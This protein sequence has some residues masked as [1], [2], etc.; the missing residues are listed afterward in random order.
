MKSR[1]DALEQRVVAWCEAR[2]DIRAALVVGSRARDD[3][4][5]DDWA[6][7]DVGIVC[8][9]P[10]R[11]LKD[12]GWLARIG[13]PLVASMD[14]SGVTVHVLFEDGADGG[15]AFIPLGTVKTALRLLPIAMRFPG[16]ARALPGG[17]AILRSVEEA[18]EYYRRGSRIIIDKDGL[19]ARMMALFPATSVAAEPPSAEEFAGSVRQ[20]WFAAVWMAKHLRRG[21]LWRTLGESGEGQ[22]RVL[23]LRMIEWRTRADRGWD[24]DVWENGRFIEEWAAPETLAALRGVLSHYDE[25]YA[26]RSLDAAMDLFARLSQDVASR[27]NL[28]LDTA[29]SERCRSIVDEVR[30]AGT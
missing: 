25:A 13:T 5:A 16:V 21:E 10:A 18:K 12:L 28:P 8:E 23:L 27:L 14:P 9:K 24:V 4:P 3:H 22:L 11:Y 15:F 2:R 29:M 1:V 17:K 7:L 30:A 20:F 6:D 26:W 19:G